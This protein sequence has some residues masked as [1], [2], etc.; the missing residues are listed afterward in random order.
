MRCC[1]DWMMCDDHYEIQLSSVYNRPHFSVGRDELD[2]VCINGITKSM[3]SSG[4]EVCCCAA[5]LEIILR[6]RCRTANDLA[7]ELTLWKAL[8]VA[9]GMHPRLGSKS[10][11]AGL[12]AE[13][14]RIILEF[15]L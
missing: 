5:R 3:M 4:L 8:P 2:H 14:V 6:D 13:L 7:D 10:P 1:D 15:A 9:M 12:S 11:L